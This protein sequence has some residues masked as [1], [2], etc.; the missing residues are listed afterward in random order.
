MEQVFKVVPAS[1]VPLNSLCQSMF[2]TKVFKEFSLG[3]I[4]ALVVLVGPEVG[5][6]SISLG[7][8]E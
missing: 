6:V 2:S 8:P 3:H 1:D 4:S 7:S 5:R